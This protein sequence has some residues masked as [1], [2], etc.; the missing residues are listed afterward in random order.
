QLDVE[1]V[2]RAVGD[3]VAAQVD[4]EQGEVADH[5]Q[6][7][8]P[9]WLVAET[10]AIVERTMRAE[11]EQVRRRRP[12]AQPLTAKLLRLVQQQERSA[13]SQL[14]RERGRSDFLRVNLSADRRREAV[15][16]EVGERAA[17]ALGGM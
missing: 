12:L 2:S 7:L 15:V 10:Q 11:D 4:A 5:V 17:V 1:R 14:L 13:R 6:H 16:E 9:G 3:D 8:V